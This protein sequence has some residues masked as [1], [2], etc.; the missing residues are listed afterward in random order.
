MQTF[1]LPCE[2]LVPD[3]VAVSV[4]CVVVASV[5]KQAAEA[6]VGTDQAAALSKCFR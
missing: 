5:D 3:S 2:H 1:V 4:G 6:G